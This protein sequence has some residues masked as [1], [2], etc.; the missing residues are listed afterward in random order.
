MQAALVLL[1]LGDP[2]DDERLG[3]QVAFWLQEM[4]GSADA[5]TISK[6]GFLEGAWRTQT[7]SQ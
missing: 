4:E 3:Q 1:E 6:H 7:V 5:A 2:Y